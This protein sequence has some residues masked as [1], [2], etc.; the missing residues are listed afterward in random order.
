[1]PK[2]NVTPYHYVLICARQYA[3]TMH[4]FRNAATDAERQGYTRMLHYL[5]ESGVTEA[6]LDRRIRTKR[7]SADVKDRIENNQPLPA[8]RVISRDEAEMIKQVYAVPPVGIMDSLSAQDMLVLADMHEGWAYDA[9]IDSFDVAR[10]L[11]WAD[12]KRALVQ[13]IGADYE[14]APKVPGEPDSLLKFIALQA[15]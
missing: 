12:G 10:L 3:A 8:G 13:A 11:G 4:K 14:P 15:E 2:V 7:L 5:I 9:R 6:E 1:M